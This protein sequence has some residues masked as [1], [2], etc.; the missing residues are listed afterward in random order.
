MQPPTENMQA[1]YVGRIAI[2]LPANTKAAGSTFLFRELEK[3]DLESIELA[4]RDGVADAQSLSSWRQSKEQELRTQPRSPLLGGNML[5]ESKEI[6]PNTYLLRQYTNTAVTTS[7][8]S[9]VL[10]LVGTSAISLETKSFDNKYPEAESRLLNILTH[11]APRPTGSN[12]PGFY[13]GPLTLKD[14]PPEIES[15]NVS[16]SLQSNPDVTFEVDTSSSVTWH[17]ELLQNREREGMS[18]FARLGVSG[19]IKIIHSGTRTVGAFEG[20]ELLLYSKAPDGRGHKFEWQYPGGSNR[21]L[22]PSIDVL[23]KTGQRHPGADNP[24]PSLDDAQARALWN[25][26]IDS[27]R[28]RSASLD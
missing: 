27:I 14:P 18:L 1:F 21:H 17:D 20:Y 23:M 5:A 9:T 24:S 16:F 6:A 22:Q 2:N 10:A 19:D 3:T 28:I 26:V 12:A 8:R 13:V 11:L 15:A 25:A 7:Y 4:I